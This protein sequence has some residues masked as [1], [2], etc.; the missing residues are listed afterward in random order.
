MHIRGII[1][2]LP[3]PTLEGSIR[4]NIYVRI[5]GWK[6]R[7]IK[8]CGL[9]CTKRISVQNAAI[10]KVGSKK[11]CICTTLGSVDGYKLLLLKSW[12][13]CYVLLALFEKGQLGKKMDTLRGKVQLASRACTALQKQKGVRKWKR[14][15]N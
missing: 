6:S 8:I 9:V 1:V 5:W 13:P 4:R 7:C 14:S 2:P 12:L 10:L 11:Y 3:S 15:R